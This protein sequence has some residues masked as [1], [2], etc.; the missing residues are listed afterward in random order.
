MAQHTAFSGDHHPLRIEK[1]PSISLKG[2]AALILC[3]ALLFGASHTQPTNADESLQIRV[4]A[5]ISTLREYSSDRSE[6]EAYVDSVYRSY[7]IVRAACISSGN[8]AKSGDSKN[9]KRMA[10]MASETLADLKSR[11]AQTKAL[12]KLHNP[13][14][15]RSIIKL[16]DDIE[17]E[18]ELLY[19]ACSR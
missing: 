18:A 11:S 5:A 9:A 6:Y 4:R 19:Q 10:S 7:A 8:Y 13:P 12:L 17:A 16:L 14:T 1:M 15:L 3:N 2:F